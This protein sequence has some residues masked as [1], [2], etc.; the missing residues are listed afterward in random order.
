MG[1]ADLKR[2]VLS[3]QQRPS[4][5]AASLQQ[6]VNTTDNNARNTPFRSDRE[7]PTDPN[8]FYSIN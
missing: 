3:Y 2:E 8:D 6:Y 7:R 5:A 4:L 1:A